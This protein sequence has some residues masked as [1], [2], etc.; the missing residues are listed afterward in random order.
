L[1]QLSTTP[2]ITV[3]IGRHSRRGVWCVW[4][5]VE[6]SETVTCL[7]EHRAPL[8][9]RL[10]GIERAVV[11][12]S[13]AQVV[14]SNGIPTNGGLPA[15]TSAFAGSTDGGG[16]SLRLEPLVERLA[17][18]RRRN[19]CGRAAGTHTAMR[20]QILLVVRARGRNSF[21]SMRRP[22]VFWRHVLERPPRFRHSECG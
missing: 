6:R 20:L 15:P 7:V 16:R 1:L 2:R 4:S 3:T 19:D 17:S 21:W 18:P 22:S 8:V 12:I 14:R 13:G 9:E 11:R 5:R 10:Q